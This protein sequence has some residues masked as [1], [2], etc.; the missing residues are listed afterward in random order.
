[1]NAV[2]S[3]RVLTAAPGK[4]PRHLT[5][6]VGRDVDL[7]ALKV[8]VRTS[9]LVTLTGTGGAVHHQQARLERLRVVKKLFHRL[10]LD[11]PIGQ[12]GPVLAPANPVHRFG[13]LARYGQRPT[14]P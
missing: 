5:S 10:Q 4:L 12:P 13:L 9:R 1:M 11:V 7:R 2:A 6:F 14:P 8:L 3:R